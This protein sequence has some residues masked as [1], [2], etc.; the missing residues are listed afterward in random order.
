MGHLFWLSDE[1]WAAI[2]PHLPTNQPGARR[3][4]DRRVISGILH[5]LKSGCRWRDCPSATVR[6]PPSTIASIAGL[7]GASG[8]AFCKPLSRPAGSRPRHRSMQPMSR[9][10]APPMAVKGGELRLRRLP[11]PPL[12]PGFGRPMRANSEPEKR[13]RRKTGLDDEA[14]RADPLPGIRD[15]L[16]CGRHTGRASLSRVCA[17]SGPP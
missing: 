14:R 17:S 11:A 2:E 5:V 6:A 16:A 10:T 8:S 12:P 1:A 9:R 7:A 13:A 3:V 4:D 15:R